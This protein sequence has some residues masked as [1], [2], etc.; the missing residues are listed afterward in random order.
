MGETFQGYIQNFVDKR[1]HE[2]MSRYVETLSFLQ[3]I[4]DSLVSKILVLE[5]ENENLKVRLQNHEIQIDKQEQYSRRTSVRIVNKWPEK[6]DENTDRMV[7]EMAS[8][9]LNT[10]LCPEEIQ[11]SHRV[12][13]PNKLPRPIIVKFLSYKSKQKICRAAAYLPFAGEKAKGIFINEDLTK[14][15]SRAYRAARNL[16]KSNVIQ[17]CWTRDGLIYIRDFTSKL[18][19]FD[20]PLKCNLWIKN[21]RLNPPKSYSTVVS[22][23]L[24]SV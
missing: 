19:V 14:P 11:R 24:V 16:K 4:V 21:E 8:M 22:T 17:D 20:N 10:E 12:G 7:M 15:R 5:E 1:V 6:Q 9:V 18:H 13:P 2:K 3:G 23:P